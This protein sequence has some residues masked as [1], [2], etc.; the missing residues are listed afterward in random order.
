MDASASILR[1]LSPYGP[2]QRGLP[3]YP[4]L[5]ALR[6]CGSSV[7]RGIMCHGL[8]GQGAWQPSLRS[9]RLRRPARAE[10]DNSRRRTPCPQC[11]VLV[12]SGRRCLL[13][14]TA[15]SHPLAASRCFGGHLAAST[16]QKNTAP[17]CKKPMRTI[18][19]SGGG[20]S[21]SIP[22]AFQSS[23]SRA[24]RVL[25]SSHYFRRGVNLPPSST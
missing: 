5:P 4:R 16:S 18:E 2:V 1:P 23:V 20:L 22:A 3:P 12:R 24:R 6:C 19:V 10:W 15:Q 7:R 21:A 14:V 11:L 13:V 9:G 25:R 8:G 17:P